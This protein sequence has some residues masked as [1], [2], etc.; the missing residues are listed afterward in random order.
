MVRRQNQQLKL[1]LVSIDTIA[2]IGAYIFAYWARHRFLF[3]EPT[4]WP[5]PEAYIAGGILLLL[6]LL[7]VFQRLGLYQARSDYLGEV[8]GIA[9]GILLTFLVVLSLS[10]FYRTFSF[11]RLVVLFF[12]PL[13][14]VFI[15]LGRFFYR[16]FSHSFAY[17]EFITRNILT[18]GCGVTGKYFI[19][20][21]QLF[22]SIYRP[23]GFL[24]DDSS[25]VKYQGIPQ[26]GTLEDLCRIIKNYNIVNVFICI[27]TAPSHLVRRLIETC[28]RMNVQWGAI[29]NLYSLSL[30]NI[31]LD[32]INGIPIIGPRDTNILGINLL[33]KRLFDFVMSS[34][35]IVLC[36][37]LM[38]LIAV[39]IKLSS[40]GPVMYKQERV[41]HNGKEFTVLKFRTMLANNDE[42]IHKEYIEKWIR[43]NECHTE[44]CNEKGIFKINEDRRI[45]G[46]GRW[47]RKFSLDE[48]P[49]F[50]NVWIGDMSMV[51]PRPALSYE[52]EMYRDWQ[53]RRLH[54]PPGITGLW[55][56]SGR[57]EISFEEMLRLDLLYIN[58]WSLENDLII[59]LKTIPTILFGKAY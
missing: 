47:L 55:Q 3:H 33:I 35:L 45:T 21:L 29:P 57:N 2:F 5:L 13:V 1:I 48:L 49:Q 44:A 14:F 58:N 50:F 24:D 34:L 4:K 8:I 30:D 19:D 16:K 51:G 43:D 40:L 12:G 38:L 7:L 23:V 31:N 36:S 32:D 53:K 54:A 46:I 27:P 56:V 25:I 6:L 15:A 20:E 37:P 17:S 26:L 22:P 11:S 42:Q 28:D 9:K 18:V 59:M 10:F 52:V 41:G 39:A